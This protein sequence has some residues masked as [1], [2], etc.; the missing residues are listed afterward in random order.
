MYSKFVLHII[1]PQLFTINHEVGQYIISF[2]SK[3]IKIIK[4]F[5]VFGSTPLAQIRSLPSRLT[6]DYGQLEASV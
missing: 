5:P 3:K 6:T 1:M 4:N 2:Q